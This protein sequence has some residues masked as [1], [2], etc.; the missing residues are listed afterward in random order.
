MANGSIEVLLA[1]GK[2]RFPKT[3]TTR[4]P[5]DCDTVERQEAPR[6]YKQLQRLL[7]NPQRDAGKGAINDPPIPL[8]TNEVYRKQAIIARK[9][10]KKYAK[11]KAYLASKNSK[12]RLNNEEEEQQ[13]KQDAVRFGEVVQAPPKISVLPKN[14]CYMP[15]QKKSTRLI[16]PAQ[17]VIKPS[18]E[19]EKISNTE[20]VQWRKRKLK[21]LPESERLSLL[22]E[23]QMIID[24]YRA[25]KI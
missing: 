10:T 3:R 22:K 14:K 20:H 23:R 12:K 9:L 15:G 25:S 4:D 2:S 19:E 13:T 24:N 1:M 18:N 17:T 11:R 16:R 5:T 8:D 7:A 6:K 21:E